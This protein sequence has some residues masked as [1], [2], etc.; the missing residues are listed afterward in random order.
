MYISVI[1]SVNYLGRHSVNFD[2]VLYG[3]S[4][5]VI[6]VWPTVVVTANVQ[7][8]CNISK[9]SNETNILLGSLGSLGLYICLWLQ[10][11]IVQNFQTISEN[12]N[13]CQFQAGFNYSPGTDLVLVW[14]PAEEPASNHSSAMQPQSVRQSVR[15]WLCLTLLTF[16][17]AWWSLWKSVR[18]CLVLSGMK[19]SLGSLVQ[20]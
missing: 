9:C 3:I 6:R 10:L 8:S 19:T 13:N 14:D 11:E 15:Q 20:L 1:S 7:I 17:W 12:I 2:P 4:S 18:R 16:P 5:I